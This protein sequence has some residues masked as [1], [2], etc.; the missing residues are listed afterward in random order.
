MAK[1]IKRYSEKHDAYFCD[2][3]NRWLED[4]C[5]DKKCDF[6]KDRPKRPKKEGQEK[7]RHEENYNGNKNRF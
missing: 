1:C 5:G 2:K 6:C 3:Y 7:L 4:G